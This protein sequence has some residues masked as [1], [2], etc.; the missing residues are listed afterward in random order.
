M[1]SSGLSHGLPGLGEV[2]ATKRGKEGAKCRA[3]QD[4]K[5]EARVNNEDSVSER[6]GRE[7]GS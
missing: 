5:H 4:L 2:K 1:T 3:T 6:R 7:G